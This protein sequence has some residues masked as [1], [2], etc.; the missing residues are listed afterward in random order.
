MRQD[1]LED[2]VHTIMETEK[3]CDRLFANCR[4]RK[5]ITC[6]SPGE[7]LKTQV[8]DVTLCLRLNV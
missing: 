4:T 7:G 5:T 2:V 8:D 1:L 3:S 6:L